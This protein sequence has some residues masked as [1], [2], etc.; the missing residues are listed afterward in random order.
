MK[1]D[2]DRDLQRLFAA[3]APVLPEE[4]FL[5]QTGVALLRQIRRARV[6]SVIG[7]A[8][9]GVIGVA[10]AA[11]TAGPLNAFCTAIEKTVNSANFALPPVAAQ[12]VVY[13]TTAAVLILGR[14]RIRAFLGPW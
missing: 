10:V 3:Y 14:R 13:A 2:S 1:D 6:R 8:L 9:L 5:A 7:Y 11:A 4:P 12:A